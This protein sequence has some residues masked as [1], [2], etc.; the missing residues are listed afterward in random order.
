VTC[1]E[2]PSVI[3]L[4]SAV[5]LTV[6]LPPVVQSG[7]VQPEEVTVTIAD[8]VAVPL[9]FV[10]VAPKTKV[11]VAFGVSS[12]VLLQLTPDQL[13]VSV[14]AGAGSPVAT[15]VTCVELPSVIVSG[16]AVT[17]TVGGVLDEVH[18]GQEL[19]LAV[20]FTF[21]EALEEHGPL[22]GPLLPSEELQFS[23]VP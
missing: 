8:D 13:S 15:T 4:G 11:P 9:A 22:P 2:S 16:F 3:V 21:M 18:V 19:L 12:T 7:P 17:L 6:G 1:V 23:D 10:A 14:Q 5:T 20:N